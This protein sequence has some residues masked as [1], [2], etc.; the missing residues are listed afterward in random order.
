MKIKHYN[1]MMAYL[2]RPGFNGGG[3]VSNRTVLPKRKPAAEVK[4]R[5]KINYEKIKQYLGKE[6]QELIERELGFAQGGAINPRLLKQKFIELVSSIQDAQPEEI[7][8]IVA[9]AKEIKD[10]IDELN[11]TLSPERQIKI[12]S[13]GI[14]FDNPLLDAAKIE[15]AVMPT[16]EVTGGLTKDIV[17]ESL[18]TKNPALKAAPVFPKGIKGTL[19]DP[20]EKE[21]P[22]PGRRVGIDSRGNVVQASMKMGRRTDKNI[23]DYLKRKLSPKR[24]DPFDPFDPTATEGS[25]AEGGSVETPKRGLVDG[26]G[27]Y[28]QEKVPSPYLNDKKFLKFLN[29]NYPNQ[30]RDKLNTA[31]EA[32][33]RML[34]K[35]DK[36]IGTKGLIEALGED[37][38]YSKDVIDRAFGNVGDRTIKKNMSSGQKARIKQ[39]NK[40][41]KI[42]VDTIGEPKSYADEMKKYRYLK[43]EVE[44]SDFKPAKGQ[45]FKKYFELDNKKIKALNKALNE[46]Y[47]KVGLRANTIDNIYNLFNDKEFM[48]S[49]KS[50]KGGE[51][52]LDSALF[53]KVFK[54]GLAGERSYAYMM[55]GRALRG[56]IELEGIKKNKALGNKIIKSIAS[57]KNL[58][59]YGNMDKAALRWAKFQ[60]AKHFDD[61]KANYDTITRTISKAFRDA[62]I[63]KKL[64]YTLVTD[65]IFP[66]RTGQLTIKGS[67]AYNQ[68]VQFIDKSINENAKRAFD[69]KASTRYQEIIKEMK[70]KNPDFTRVEDLVKAHKKAVKDFYVNNPEAKGKVKLTQ[71]NYNPKTRK[72]APPTEIYGTDLPPKILSDMEKFYRKTGLS[73]DVGTTM[74]LEKAAANIEN[75]VKNLPKNSQMNVCRKLNVKSVGDLV[76]D[77]PTLI[78]EKPNQTLT[79]IQEETKR[80]PKKTG[81]EVLKTVNKIRQGLKVTGIGLL[82]EVPFEFLAGVNPYKR[83]KPMDEIIDE[84]ILGLYGIGRDLNR[85][86][87]E[88]FVNTTQ[89]SGAL[90]FYDYYKDQARLNEI[91]TTLRRLSADQPDA[92]TSDLL[93]EKELIEGRL[94]AEPTEQ[95]VNDFEIFIRRRAGEFEANK[96]ARGQYGPFTN[97]AQGTSLQSF[98]DVAEELNIDLGGILGDLIL[99]ERENIIPTT[100]RKQRRDKDFMRRRAEGIKRLE[101]NVLFPATDSSFAGGG[102][103]KQAGVESGVAPESGPNSQGLAFLM[104]RGR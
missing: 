17:P 58:T 101:Q 81:D 71:L 91:D 52:D 104:K 32:Y 23:M 84:S 43:K 95:D 3:A 31:Y 1:E 35:K 37:N 92:D 39:A 5:K 26:P 40:I 83:G 79:A 86:N 59:R 73:L 10:K 77:C 41:R 19:A 54:P 60:M 69:G 9:E 97:I 63:N 100:T 6:S 65:E 8:L 38:P 102:I 2:T 16:P 18:T 22:K 82:T 66:A 28:S 24:F 57:D 61:P 7:P 25:F 94:G 13:Q 48:K 70:G 42:I 45:G 29:E 56:E 99:P 27:S 90:K 74:T 46:N 49:L 36:I 50:Y 93:Q 78:A 75:I 67:G 53:K 47:R 55:L 14:D 72:F 51:V 11:Q 20:E 98:S 76:K 62:G 96:K 15:E 88:E 44:R 12:T 30:P 33:E 89:R 103:A 4:K 34:L 21:D 85:P 87:V 80:L 64:G 68:F